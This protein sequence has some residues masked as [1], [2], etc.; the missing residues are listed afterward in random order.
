MT[1]YLH[2]IDCLTDITSHIFILE[3]MEACIDGTLDQVDLQFEDNAA[4][5]FVLASEGYPVSYEKGFPSLSR[6]EHVRHLS[7]SDLR[8]ILFLHGNSYILRA[9]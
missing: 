1:L 4:V 3:V 2:F 8:R 5:C 9:S 6:Q 7:R